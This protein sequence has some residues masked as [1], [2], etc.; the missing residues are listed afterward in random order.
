MI[1]AALFT[2][3]P[4]KCVSGGHGCLCLKPSE[5]N[6]GA[7]ESGFVSVCFILGT[8]SGCGIPGSSQYLPGEEPVRCR[9]ESLPN[10]FWFKPND[11]YTFT[12]ACCCSATKTHTGPQTDC[13]ACC[14]KVVNS[15]ILLCWRLVTVPACSMSLKAFSSLEVNLSPA[16]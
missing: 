7:R 13:S 1:Y 6:V 5:E 15:H 8:P 2:C 3:S 14:G 10:I 4:A 11:D 9:C 12:V 16:S